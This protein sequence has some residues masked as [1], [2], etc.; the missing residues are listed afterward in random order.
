MPHFSDF[1]CSCSFFVFT[2]NTA[3]KTHTAETNVVHAASGRTNE[4]SMHSSV[5]SGSS[6][7][8]HD[9]NLCLTC[10]SDAW[11]IPEPDSI[12]IACIMY[13]VCKC[14]LRCFHDMKL[15]LNTALLWIPGGISLN[16]NE[17]AEVSRCRWQH[18]HVFVPEQW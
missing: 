15:S 8:L 9:C 5:S 13:Y 17:G 3:R 6:L 10:L 11:F 2:I 12:N 1:L 14:R 18:L 7:R 4:A 16:A